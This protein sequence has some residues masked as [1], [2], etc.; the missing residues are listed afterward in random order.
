MGR[1]VKWIAFVAARQRRSCVASGVVDVRVNVRDRVAGAIDLFG[2][3]ASSRRRRPAEPFWKEGGAERAA[4][5]RRPARPRA[6]PT[7]PSARRPRS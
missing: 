3:R 5:G 7:S 1:V 6:S 2:E 4:A